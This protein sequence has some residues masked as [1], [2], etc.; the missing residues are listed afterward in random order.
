MAPHEDHTAREGVEPRAPRR[1]PRD[2]TPRS[3]RD[4]L[5]SRTFGHWRPGPASAWRL[6]TPATPEADDPRG[7]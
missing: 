5:G 6:A 1:Q 2:T 7:P 4:D 3:T